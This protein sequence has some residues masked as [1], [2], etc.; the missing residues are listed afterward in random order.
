MLF[1][2]CFSLSMGVVLNPEPMIE[3]I[4]ALRIRIV[5]L[6]SGHLCVLQKRLFQDEVHPEFV[7]KAPDSY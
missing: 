7:F 2:L 6:Q 5:W 4:I 1:C 3:G